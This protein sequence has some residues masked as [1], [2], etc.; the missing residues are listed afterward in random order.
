MT[1]TSIYWALAAM[2][3]G[4]VCF[5]V[6]VR[7]SDMGDPRDATDIICI[8]FVVCLILASFIFFVCAG[9]RLT[10]A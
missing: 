4:W 5:S 9:I 6:G 3:F 2:A 10:A 7:M 1:N 8:V